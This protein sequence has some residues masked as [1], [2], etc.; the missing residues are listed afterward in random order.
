MV[1]GEE[2]G[3]AEMKGARQYGDKTDGE[4]FKSISVPAKNW[5]RYFFIRNYILACFHH[6]PLLYGI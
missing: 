6:P 1:L 5:N 4:E 2:L 3:G